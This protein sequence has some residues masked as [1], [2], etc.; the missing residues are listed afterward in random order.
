MLW[1]PSVANIGASGG[2]IY[3]V[4]GSAGFVQQSTGI[5]YHQ[6]TPE[7]GN[8]PDFMRDYNTR[9]M[10][11]TKIQEG[12]VNMMRTMFAYA[13][14]QAP[15][16]VNDIKPTLKLDYKP[17]P[18]FYLKIKSNQ[19][20]TKSSTYAKSVFVVANPKDAK[21]LQVNDLIA[22]NFAFV[23]PSKDA[24]SVAIDYV[25]SPPSG[26]KFVAKR[27]PLTPLQEV[28]RVLEVD[29]L[30]GAVTVLR[31]VGNDT[32]TA[33]RTGIA[34][35]V[36]ANATTDPGTN[37]INAADAFFVR[38][39]NSLA[40]G[41]DDQMIYSRNPTWDYNTCQYFMRKWGSQDIESAIQ[42]NF[43]GFDNTHQKNRR[44]TLED[45]FEELE[46]AFLYSG[47]NEEY[48]AKGK[49]AGTL[50]GF[51]ES[52]P[53][54]NY[55]EMEEPNY[56]ATGKMGDFTISR[57]NK[58]LSD[59]FYYGAQEKILVCGER[60]H[61]AFSIMLNEKTNNLSQIVDRWD[62]RG[63]YFQCSNG[64]RLFVVP[65]D[66]LSL[67]GNNDIACLYDPETF[68]YGYLN[69]FD[70][71]VVDPLPTTNIHEEEGEVFGVLT[72]KRT[73]PHSNY[74][75]VLKPNNGG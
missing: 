14:Q 12:R 24:N 75:F 4:A 37:V 9:D 52:V 23:P 57:L 16:V 41:T 30:S 72:A 51:F 1:N 48:N 39:G 63:L 15:W 31:N 61:T 60:W 64:G 34:I 17:N 7:V 20:G 10:L 66:T 8:I 27:E 11:V 19:G 45:F 70:I 53:L 26:G 73:N 50:G 6:G 33:T 58:I 65:S 29:Y 28:S 56:A 2:Y 42:K 35:D 62:V 38:I 47:R 55:V 46:F 13:R 67:N 40:A 49:W 54:T 74:I 5:P 71:D 3:P 32:R 25:E 43:P 69:G 21:R 18:R 44:D 68:R 22:L 59:K 36:R